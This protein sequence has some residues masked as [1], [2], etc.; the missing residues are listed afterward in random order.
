MTLPLHVEYRHE[1]LALEKRRLQK[2]AEAKLG[3]CRPICVPRIV[4]LEQLNHIVTQYE[5]GPVPAADQARIDSLADA[6]RAGANVPP[7]TLTQQ[8]R[9]R[10]TRVS[11][12]TDGNHR[13]TAARIAGVETIQVVQ[14][15]PPYM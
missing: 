5:H 14:I 8:K 10:C 7:I 11:R 4:R 13:L 2:I 15:I 3:V 12:L 1:A 9:T 6:Y